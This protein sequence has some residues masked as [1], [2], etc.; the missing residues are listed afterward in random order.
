MEGKDEDLVINAL[1]EVMARA[2]MLG[3]SCSENKMQGSILDEQNADIVSK[4]M[5]LYQSTDKFLTAVGITKTADEILPLY[6]EI[7]S[8]IPQ[9]R[10]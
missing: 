4:F 5:S 3:L 1:K 2:V 7:I 6:K 10:R 8:Q 9:E